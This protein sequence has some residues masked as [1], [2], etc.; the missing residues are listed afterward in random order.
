MGFELSFRYHEEISKNE[1]NKEELK[2]K[3]LKIG[4]P[5]DEIPLEAVASRIMSQLARR[6]I[7]IVDVEIYEYTKKKISYKE[8]SDGILIKNRK[9]SFDDGVN[10]T[11]S[12]ETPCEPCEEQ[13]QTQA[14]QLVSNQQLL[15]QLLAS[16]LAGNQNMISDIMKDKASGINL[17][18]KPSAFNGKALRHEIFN[19]LEK[20]MI[21]DCQRRGMAF[22]LGKSYP[23]INERMAPNQMA[24]MMYTT[25]DN[26][27]NRHTLSDKFFTPEVSNLEYGELFE[28]E[29]VPVSSKKGSSSDGLDWSGTLEEV[30]PLKV[31]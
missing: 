3:V 7:L 8:V 20:E 5:Y 10:L 24:G 26:N 1:Y 9:F 11:S 16:L 6:N 21:V 29:F 17:A 27:G 2:E 31:R 25:I 14:A 13:G 30:E 12:V 4:S 23:I 22:T 15:Q 28:E 19:P 18:Q